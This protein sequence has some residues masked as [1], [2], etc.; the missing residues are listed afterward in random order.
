MCQLSLNKTGGKPTI[1]IQP[2]YNLA[3]ALWDNKMK[4]YAHTKSCT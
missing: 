3:T 1:C 4:S 2:P